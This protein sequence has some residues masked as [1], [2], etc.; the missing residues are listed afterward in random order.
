MIDVCSLWVVGKTKNHFRTINERRLQETRER[1]EHATTFDEGDWVV[2]SDV[3]LKD[4]E[5]KL[6]SL[7][8]K[9]YGPYSI[10]GLGRNHRV[11]VSDVT[12]KAEKNEVKK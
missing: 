10:V 12:L 1:Y 11:L 3:T 2:V 4:G 6:P 5:R 7:A 9:K 8:A